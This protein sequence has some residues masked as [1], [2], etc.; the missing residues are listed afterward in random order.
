LPSELDRVLFA[1]GQSQ[2]YMCCVVRCSTGKRGRDFLAAWFLVMAIFTSSPYS[3]HGQTFFRLSRWSSF[4]DPLPVCLL[5]KTFHTPPLNPLTPGIHLIHLL[6]CA[7]LVLSRSFVFCSRPPANSIS[8]K[9]VYRM[10]HNYSQD[11]LE[12]TQTENV[13]RWA[14]F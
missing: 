9:E 14:S 11:S 3:K 4:S 1:C 7:A 13:L 6:T 2:R 12:F 8:S 10:F 5:A